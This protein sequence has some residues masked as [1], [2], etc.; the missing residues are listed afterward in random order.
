MTT[1]IPAVGSGATLYWWTD[2]HA[3]TVVEVTTDKTTFVIV[4]EDS[5]VRVDSNG[6]SDSQTWDCTPDP[7]GRKFVYRRN[8]TKE[9][10]EL[11][12]FN[13]KTKRWNLNE[14]QSPKLG[15]NHRN[16]FF[17]FSF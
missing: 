6:M 13:E 1:V 11:V 14:T 12:H 9:A 3:A 16:H 10:W 2:R 7:E 4:Q 8:E 17:D 15:I 5:A